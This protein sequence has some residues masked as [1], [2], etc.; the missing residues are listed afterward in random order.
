MIYTNPDHLLVDW[1]Q[2]EQASVGVP[3]VLHPDLFWHDPVHYQI[4]FDFPRWLERK[5]NELLQFAT[6]R[7]Q[8]LLVQRVRNPHV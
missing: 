8:D 6:S 4:S 1:K 7:S 2:L 5:S 3:S